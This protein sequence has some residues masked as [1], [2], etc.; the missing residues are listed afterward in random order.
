VRRLVY[1]A[2]AQRDLLSIMEYIARESGSLATARRF[3]D[4]L[5]SHCRKLAGLS[6]TLGR[7]R[8]E[9]AS[10][11]RSSPFRGYVVFFRYRASTLEIVNILEGHRDVS[12]HFGDEPSD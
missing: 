5:R 4:E 9:L 11:V 3:T 7:A 6:S 1:L 10:G 2:A 8:P 12:L